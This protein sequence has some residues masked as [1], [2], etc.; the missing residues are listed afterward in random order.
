MGILIYTYF[1]YLVDLWMVG[2]EYITNKSE[3]ARY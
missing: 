2:M 1:A 3:S